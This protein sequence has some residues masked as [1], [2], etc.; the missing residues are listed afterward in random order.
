MF[1][2]NFQEYGKMFISKLRLVSSL[3]CHWKQHDRPT[4]KEGQPW[5]YLS[6]GRREESRGNAPPT[7]PNP[8][9]SPSFPC[10]LYILPS[11][12]LSCF[13]F[14]LFSL[15]PIPS[16]IPPSPSLHLLLLIPHTVPSLLPSF[17]SSLFYF[18]PNFLMSDVSVCPNNLLIFFL[19]F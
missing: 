10:L 5:F 19:Y 17:F 6:A 4:I 15:S 13:P 3:L 8:T 18:L 1:C 16:H 9:P 2:P 7:P 11:P 12:P 14:N